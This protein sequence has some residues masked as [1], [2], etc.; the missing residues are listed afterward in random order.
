MHLNLT[1][2]DKS[3]IYRLF[4]HTVVPRP[5]AWVLTENENG[6]YN[7]AP[8]SYFNVISSDP[9]LLMFS[10]G[11]KRDGSKKDSW[12]NIER[13][14]KAVVHIADVSLMDALN[15]S[16]RGL[17]AEVSEFENLNLPLVQDEGFDLPRI[18]G[19]PVAYNTK[20]YD[21]HLLGNGPQAVIYLE[22]TAAFVNDRLWLDDEK[23]VDEAKLAPLARLG[24]ERYSEL[25]PIHTLARPS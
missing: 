24:G 17:P 23:R 8:F 3:E 16:A 4:T 5:I 1:E 21:I 10:A 20:R 22:A 12:R 25:G 7:L 2:Q 6:T 18:E 9:A 19:A 14:G 13:N 15:E 11:H